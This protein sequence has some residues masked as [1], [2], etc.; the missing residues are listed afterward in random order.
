[1]MSHFN[2]AYL[3]IFSS[4]TESPR[5]FMHFSDNENTYQSRSGIDFLEFFFRKVL[6]FLWKY[7]ILQIEANKFGT[8]YAKPLL[9]KSRFCFYVCSL[10]AWL[11]CVSRQFLKNADGRAI[12]WQKG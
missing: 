6:H 9:V 4:A 2:S 3:F 7:C 11:G 5:I 12:R 1:M 8:G 10:E